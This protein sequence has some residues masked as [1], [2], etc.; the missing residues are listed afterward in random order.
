MLIHD[1]AWRQLACLMMAYHSNEQI[2][3]LGVGLALSS[4]N[5]SYLQHWP[6]GY[7]C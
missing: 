1:A 5:S 2:T 6:T 3:L 7:F 4:R